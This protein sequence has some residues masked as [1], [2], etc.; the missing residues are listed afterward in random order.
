M[1]LG[2]VGLGF[3]A[4]LGS[5]IVAALGVYLI[6]TPIRALHPGGIWALEYKAPLFWIGFASLSVAITAAL[7]AGF[8]KRSGSPTWP[9]A[10]CSGGCC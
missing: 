10:P 2:G 5:M 3:L 9:W 7:Y 4:L 8:R 6:W 1:T